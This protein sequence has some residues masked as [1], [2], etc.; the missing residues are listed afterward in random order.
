[1][2]VNGK[3]L[4]FL[5]REHKLRGNRYLLEINAYPEL[6]DL[7]QVN[8]L[9]LSNLAQEDQTIGIRGSFTSHRGQLLV[10]LEGLLKE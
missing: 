10:R 3:L 4:E 1:M 5:P 8:T 6:E 9:A 2:H 7:I